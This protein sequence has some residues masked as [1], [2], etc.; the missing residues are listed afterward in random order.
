MKLSAV[1]LVFKE[2]PFLIPVLAGIYPV[3]DSICVVTAY[4]RNLKGDYIE[5]DQTVKKPLTFKQAFQ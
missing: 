3:V 1:V 4:D 2:D 5:P